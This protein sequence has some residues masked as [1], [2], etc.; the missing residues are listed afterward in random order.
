VVWLHENGPQKN[1]VRIK[2]VRYNELLLYAYR[3]DFW[4]VM[5]A[6]KGKRTHFNASP[7]CYPQIPH[8]WSDAKAD[9]HSCCAQEEEVA[10]EEQ[11]ALLVLHGVYRHRCGQHG[12][13]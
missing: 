8:C 11:P 10:E 4:H 3:P 13:L 7:H 9:M 2:E 12:H 1:E 6:S 5:D